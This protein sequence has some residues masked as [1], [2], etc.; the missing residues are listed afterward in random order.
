M[1]LDDA[2]VARK[3]AALAA[4]RSQVCRAPPLPPTT[5]RP[6]LITMCFAVSFVQ[7]SSPPVAAVRWTAGKVGG[8]FSMEE[9]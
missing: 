9:S 5:T 7:Y 6:L 2:L 1:E 4:H 3:A 8:Q